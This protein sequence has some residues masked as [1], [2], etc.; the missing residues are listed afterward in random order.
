LVNVII[1]VNVISSNPQT[2]STIIGKR[3]RLMLSLIILSI[4]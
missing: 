1:L 4:G 3:N 2:H